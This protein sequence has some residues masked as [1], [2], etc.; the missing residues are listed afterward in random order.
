M[1]RL[2]KYGAGAGLAVCLIG[3]LFFGSDLTSMIRTTAKSVQKSVKESVPLEFELQRAKEKIGEILP[4]LQSQVRMIAEEEVAIAKLSKEI[5]VDAAKLQS[6][7]SKLTS[8]RENMRVQQISYRVGRIDLNRQQ[9]AEYFQTRFNHFKQ[10]RIS[11]QTKQ[12]LLDKRKEGLAAAVAMLDQM[13]VRQSELKLKVEALA[14]QH[15]LIKSSQIESG[16]LVDGSQLSQADQLLDQ[17]ETRLQVAQRVMNYQEESLDLPAAEVVVDEQGVLS[18]FD[19]Y[20]GTVSSATVA[21][22]EAE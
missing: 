21:K 17:I 18:A 6:H 14:A 10:S 5:V 3:F 20:V 7:E 1:L 8:M 16:T 2:L 15:R 9:M 11:L 12:K 22:S 19:E 13:R 4:D